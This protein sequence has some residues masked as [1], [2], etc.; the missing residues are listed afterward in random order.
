MIMVIAA[1]RLKV[2]ADYAIPLLVLRALEDGFK[3]HRAGHTNGYWPLV[4]EPTTI[5]A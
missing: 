4:H 5:V 3:D 2:Y 1:A